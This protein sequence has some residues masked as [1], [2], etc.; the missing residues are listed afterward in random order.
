[1]QL[2][3]WHQI[4]MTCKKDEKFF[5]N[6]LTQKIFITPGGDLNGQKSP[7][8]FFSI[9]G[10]RMAQLAKRKQ[11]NISNFLSQKNSITPA[12]VTS[13]GQKSPKIFFFIFGIRLTQFAKKSKKKFLTQIWSWN[14][15]NVAQ[16]KGQN[17]FTG[18]RVIHRWNC[19]TMS[20]LN[21]NFQPKA[22]RRSRENAEK[23]HF[24]A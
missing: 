12:G 6:F 9:L 14:V 18:R 3:F 13:N 11:K 10:I 19:L 21:M 7:K 24:W 22:L 1:M 20:Y 15:W 23:P 16:K 5:L 17:D 4:R 2:S 8:Y